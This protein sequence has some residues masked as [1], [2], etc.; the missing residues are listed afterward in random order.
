MGG[1]GLAQTHLAWEGFKITS[2]FESIWVSNL[3]RGLSKRRGSLLLNLNFLRDK[4]TKLRPQR[5]MVKS[6]KVS[7]SPLLAVLSIAG[8]YWPTHTWN[9]TISSLALQIKNV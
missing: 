7:W 5:I 2:L 8:P 1:G 3:R 9:D 6:S 4:T